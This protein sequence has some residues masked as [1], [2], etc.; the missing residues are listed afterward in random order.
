MKTYKVT[1]IGQQSYII[2]KTFENRTKEQ[3]NAIIDHY[4]DSYYYRPQMDGNSWE[5]NGDTYIRIEEEATFNFPASVGLTAL[6]I[7]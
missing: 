5:L 3:V 1:I 6:G 7:N 2:G 4:W